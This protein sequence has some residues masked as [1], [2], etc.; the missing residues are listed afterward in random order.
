M[1]RFELPGGRGVGAG[2]VDALEF[3]VEG[4]HCVGPSAWVCVV[5]FH[6]RGADE[7]DRVK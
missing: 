7:I 1:K 2:E 4:R 5:E 6:E 3:W